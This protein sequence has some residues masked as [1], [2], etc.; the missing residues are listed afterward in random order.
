[1]REWLGRKSRK[2]KTH[3]PLCAEDLSVV[4]NNAAMLREMVQALAPTDRISDGDVLLDLH[5]ACEEMRTR[6][7]SLIAMVENPDMLS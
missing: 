2:N 1:M 5:V 3:A 7:T 4:G 6:L